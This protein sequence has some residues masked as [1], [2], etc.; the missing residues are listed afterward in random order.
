MV[1]NLGES[2]APAEE[3]G[4]RNLARAR[5]M[6]ALSDISSVSA[7]STRS[8]SRISDVVY[9]ELSEAIRDLRLPPGAA[10]SEPGVAASLGVSRAP[11]R[12]AFTRLADQGLVTIRPQVGTTVAP[13]SMVEVN[14]A[15]FIRSALE[16]S[17]FQQRHRPRGSRCVR[18]AGARRPESGCRGP[19]R[20]RGLLPVRRGAAPAG[21]RDRRECR[22]SGRSCAARRSTSTDCAGS[23]SAA[24]WRTRRSP[25]S[26]STSSTRS[27]SATS[28]AASPSSTATPPGSSATPSKLRL[29]YP[30][31]FIS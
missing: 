13:I 30:D 20:R 2:A 25:P 26:I 16:K 21:V 4:A 10:L 23:T 19:W 17:A 15:V 18:A 28:R 29:E 31:Y 7:T 24:R 5:S 14:D 12:E 9:D 22:G 27:V 6:A 11:V 3:N 1:I 8:R